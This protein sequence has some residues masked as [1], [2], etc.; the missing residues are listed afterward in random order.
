MAGTV[1]R[2][3]KGFRYRVQ[4]GADPGGA[5]PIQRPGEFDILSVTAAL[6]DN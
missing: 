4:L 5:R 6:C 3:G 2:Y 1:E